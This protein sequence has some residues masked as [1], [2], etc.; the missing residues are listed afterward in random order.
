VLVVRDDGRG[1]ARLDGNGLTGMRERVEALGG[2]LSVVSLAGQGTELELRLPFRTPAGG[3][4]GRPP[5]RIVAG[6][7]TAA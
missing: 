6:R 3:V 1:G 5:L 7:A 2:A 4:E